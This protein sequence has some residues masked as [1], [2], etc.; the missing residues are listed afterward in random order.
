MIN[1]LKKLGPGLLFAGAAIGVSHL[2]QSTRAGADFG[3]SLIWALILANF[4]KYPFFLFGPRYTLATGETLLHGYMKMN[5]LYLITYFLL[6]IVTMFTIQTAVT[7]V[8]AGLAIELFGLS[9]NITIWATT[10]TFSCVLILIIGRYRFLDNLMKFVIILLTISTVI[11]V[12]F[13]G[14]NY[15][16]PV[17]LDQII[18]KNQVGL[19][20]LAA[21]IGWMPAPLDV[22]IWQSIWTLEKTKKEE[23]F[24][25]KDALFDFNIGY[26]TTILLGISFLSL[27][28]F[29]MYESGEVFSNS[30]GEFAKQ[31]IK[32]YTR[33]IGNKVFLI[34]AIAA[35]TT[36][37]STTIT[38]LDASP[39]AMKIT[40]ELLNLKG[41]KSYNTWIIILSLGTLSIFIFFISEMGLLVKIATIL[42]FI[43]AP[44]YAFINFKLINSSHTPEKFKPSKFMNY[45][46]VFGIIL[47]TF[48]SIWYITIL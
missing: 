46:S 20:F 41:F 16:N 36:M 3:F 29:V 14:Y 21:F 30:G 28:A 24:K 40:S 11:A 38:C 33:S 17:N 2:V 45:F 42:S 47:L 7:I 39:R 37:L 19:V 22:S 5:K 15:E 35:F 26:L 6:S 31:L 23:K 10:I 27:G 4:I 48:F 43:T 9:S 44:F 18:P 25:I 8:T 13:A 1:F 32:L 12:F 34:I